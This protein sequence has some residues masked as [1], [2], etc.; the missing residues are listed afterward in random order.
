MTLPLDNKVTDHDADPLVLDPV[1]SSLFLTALITTSAL[2]VLAF[3][4]EEQVNVLR[5]NAASTGGHPDDA[6][7]DAPLFRPEALSTIAPTPHETPPIERP[8]GSLIDDTPAL[9]TSPREDARGHSDIHPIELRQGSNALVRVGGLQRVVE[10]L[11][12]VEGAI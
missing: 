7:I 2:N 3:I 5:P 11:L 12:H 10:C 4:V 9:G 8:P 1:P 6:A